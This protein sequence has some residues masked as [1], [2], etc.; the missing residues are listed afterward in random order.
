M[1]TLML[2]TAAALAIST[3]AYANDQM[4]E[5][6]QMIFETNGIYAD[7]S[8]LPDNVLTEIY[9]LESADSNNEGGNTTEIR[10]ILS[11]AGWTSMEMPDG[12]VAWYAYDIDIEPN[13]L[14]DHVEIKLTEFGYDVEGDDLTDSQVAELFAI[15]QSTD[16]EPSR[17]LIEQI[18]Q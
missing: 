14:R 17:G 5:N 11:D 10:Q 18:I 12:K 7:A 6:V 9:A 8:A 13:S 16:G 2:S 3:A 1:K 15:V 4:E